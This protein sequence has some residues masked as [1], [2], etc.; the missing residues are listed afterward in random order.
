MG[1]NTV[2]KHIERLR[3][4]IN[5]AFRLGWI[6]SDPFINFKVS[7]LKAKEDFKLGRASKDYT[8]EF[9]NLQIGIGKGLV[10]F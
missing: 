4:L 1:N 2:M 8:Q 10:C 3:K 5:L 6:E 9:Y 7:L